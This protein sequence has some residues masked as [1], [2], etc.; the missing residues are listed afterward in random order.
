[1]HTQIAVVDGRP[2]LFARGRLDQVAA[3]EFEAAA[4]DYAADPSGDAIIDLAGVDYIS[5]AALKV[6]KALADRHSEAGGRLR[7]RG[8][9]VAAKL[10]LEFSGLLRLVE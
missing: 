9:S 5:S 1:L 8:P 4:A 6:L 2:V 3:A 10:A 7:L